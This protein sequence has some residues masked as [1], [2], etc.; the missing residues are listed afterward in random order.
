MFSLSVGLGAFVTTVP[1]FGKVG[2]TVRILGTNLTG[3][4]SVTFNG[5]PA[6]IT[7]TSASEIAAIVPAGATTGKVEVTTPSG[8]LTSNAVFLVLP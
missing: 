7:Y 3:T 1:T 2:A 4:V 6:T 8:T 5:T